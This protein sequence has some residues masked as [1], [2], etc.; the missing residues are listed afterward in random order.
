MDLWMI[1]GYPHFK[2]SPYVCSQ[3]ILS[4]ILS[5]VYSSGW[6]PPHWPVDVVPVP[7]N[8]HQYTHQ[9]ISIPVV[10][11]TILGAGIIIPMNWEHES[12]LNILKPARNLSLAYIHT[13][14][15]CEY[16]YIHIY[17]YI[18]IHIYTYIYIHIYT[19]IYV[20]TVYMCIHISPYL[21]VEKWRLM[22]EPTKSAPALRL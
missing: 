22:L 3:G 1:W 4:L 5:G 8:V 9:P 20:Y 2:K 21:L 10:F 7:R 14:F 17:I 13:I 11:F 18:Y 19:Y 15:W 6:H 12:I 16:I